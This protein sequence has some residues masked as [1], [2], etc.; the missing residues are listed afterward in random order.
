M[1]L[2]PLAWLAY[3]AA[4]VIFVLLALVVI[5]DGAFLF[6]GLALVAFGL[7][8]SGYWEARGPRNPA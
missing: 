5:T 2:G 8:F 7:A 1:N 3:V 4:C 6:W